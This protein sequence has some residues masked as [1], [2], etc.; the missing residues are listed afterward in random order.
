MFN[1]L[2][3]GA[4]MNCHMINSRNLMNACWKSL[5]PNNIQRRLMEKLMGDLYLSSYFILLLFES[6]YERFIIVH[7][8][9]YT[10]L[11]GL[12]SA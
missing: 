10:V 4:L 7:E 3:H 1:W 5:T 8:F 11:A 12:V 9:P 2:L 6:K